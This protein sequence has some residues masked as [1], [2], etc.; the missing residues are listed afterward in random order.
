MAKN[1]GAPN[2][3]F[4]EAKRHWRKKRSQ[5]EG[6]YFSKNVAPLERLWPFINLEELEREARQ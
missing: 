2:T 6:P 4:Y 5:Q 3:V 1:G